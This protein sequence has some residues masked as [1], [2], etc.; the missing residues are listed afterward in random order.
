MNAQDRTKA[1][2]PRTRLGAIR[3]ALRRDGYGHLWR[4][5]AEIRRAAQFGCLL[6]TPERLTTTDSSRIDATPNLDEVMQ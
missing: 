6:W 3:D 2:T 4:R 5:A 1:I